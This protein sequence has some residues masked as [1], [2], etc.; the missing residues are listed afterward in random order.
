MPDDLQDT[1]R[2]AAATPQS[3]TVD[4]NS[5]TARPLKDLIDADKH[6]AHKASGGA[7]AIRLARIKP[8]G[9]VV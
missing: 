8:G 6:L 2:E 3:A 4:G 1:I 5:A 9:S 7:R